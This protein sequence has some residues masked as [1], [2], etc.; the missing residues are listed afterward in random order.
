MILL[1]ALKPVCRFERRLLHS[2][3]HV[4]LRLIIKGFAG[5]AC[6]SYRSTTGRVCGIFLFFED[7][8]GCG[9]LPLG[10]DVTRDPDIVV[11]I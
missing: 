5:A 1:L 9:L 6:Q 10:R 4:S 3:N 11:H 2:R 7:G 8:D